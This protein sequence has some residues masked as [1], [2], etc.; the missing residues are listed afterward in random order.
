MLITERYDLIM[1]TMKEKE[2]ISV[3]EL[4]VITKSS[5]AT[6]RRDLIELENK[7]LLIRVHG[8]AALAE[9]SNQEATMEIKNIIN[10][11]EK[12]TIAQYA[13]SL[14]KDGDYIFLDAGSTTYR[15]IKYLKNKKVIVVTNGIDHILELC[16]YKIITYLTGGFVKEK[17]RALVGN[18][19]LTIIKK[20]NF[21][22]AFLGVNSLSFEKGYSTPDSEEA[23]IKET[24]I[25]HS[26][27]NYML[28]DNSKFDK[29]SF[30]K[31]GDL[32]DGIIITDKLKNKKYLEKT[33]IKELF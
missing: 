32:N 23:I 16:K 8:G 24:V 27:K 31:F 13:A 4:V 21:E 7:N 17:T 6:I 2:T 25:K 29:D 20:H 28:A 10:T 3:K 5:E 22:K 11:E 30:C 33:E 19:A 9:Q 18:E 12:E 14:V 1:K 26:K 15:M